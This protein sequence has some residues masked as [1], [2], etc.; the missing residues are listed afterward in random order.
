MPAS[1]VSSF[2]PKQSRTKC[3]TGSLSKKAERIKSTKDVMANDCV[4]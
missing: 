3:L 4:K 2:F 1:M